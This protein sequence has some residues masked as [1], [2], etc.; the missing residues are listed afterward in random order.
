MVHHLCEWGLMKIKECWQLTM[1]PSEDRA[2]ESGLEWTRNVHR[3]GYALFGRLRSGC[4]AARLCAEPALPPSGRCSR[5]GRQWRGS[6][7]LSLSTSLVIGGRIE[8]P[9]EREQSWKAVLG[10]GY[11]EALSRLAKVRSVLLDALL[12]MVGAPLQP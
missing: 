11:L 6:V 2:G 8:E 3:F 5:I 4:A 1:M 7:G 9:V 10:E 12:M